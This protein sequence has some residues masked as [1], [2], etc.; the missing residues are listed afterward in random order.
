MQGRVCPVC[1]RLGFLGKVWDDDEG[2]RK[3]GSKVPESP[4]DTSSRCGKICAWDS[5]SLHALLSA[6]QE[7][8]AQTPDPAQI[9]WV[10]FFQSKR[11]N[12]VHAPLTRC[13]CSEVAHCADRGSEAHRGEATGPG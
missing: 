8:A 11:E 5:W 9:T 1:L 13:L 3:N 4:P 7:T 2:I 10:R 12:M 6:R